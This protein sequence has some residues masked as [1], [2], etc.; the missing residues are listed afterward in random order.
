L[1]PSTEKLINF[2]INFIAVKTISY[3]LDS[4]G[5]LNWDTCAS[6]A[7]NFRKVWMADVFSLGRERVGDL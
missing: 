4:K 2:N 1:F 6:H 7:Y 3:D 5:V